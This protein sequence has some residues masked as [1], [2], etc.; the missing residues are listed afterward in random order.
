MVTATLAAGVA[1]AACGDDEGEPTSGAETISIDSIADAGDVLVDPN[2]AALYSADEESDGRIGCTGGCT[3]IWVPVTVKKGQ[4]P[5]GPADIDA[6]LD[7]VKRPEG[8]A[9]VTF[10]GAPLYTFTDEGPGEVTG[11]GFQ[12]TFRGQEFTWRVI[13]PSGAGSDAGAEDSAADAGSGY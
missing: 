8:T 4:A 1:L 13:T 5:T 12:D 9:Q 7:T 6:Q 11:D 2:G 3:S 10:D